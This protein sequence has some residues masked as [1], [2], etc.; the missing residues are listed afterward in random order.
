MQKI[1]ITLHHDRQWSG[2][3]VLSKAL[4]PDIIRTD[5]VAGAPPASFQAQQKSRI[6]GTNCYPPS[7]VCFGSNSDIVTGIGECLLSPQNPT[8][9]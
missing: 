7:S 6:C 8:L 4:M 5:V 1:Q 3:I 2:V 9:K